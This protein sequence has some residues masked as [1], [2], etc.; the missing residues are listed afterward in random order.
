MGQ[1]F[2]IQRR[3]QLSKQTIRPPADSVVQSC[4]HHEDPAPSEADQVNLLSRQSSNADSDRTSNLRRS[5]YS[6]ATHYHDLPS[7]RS[8]EPHVTERLSLSSH[9]ASPKIF[10]HGSA[11]SRYEP[12]GFNAATLMR[13]TVHIAARR[14]E[15]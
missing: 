3:G 6:I 8:F 9:H 1:C 7:R 10:R 12:A 5:S 14:D 4:D 2:G 11:I 13:D 15:D